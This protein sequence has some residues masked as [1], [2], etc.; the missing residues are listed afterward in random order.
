MLASLETTN[1]QSLGLHSGLGS[2][3]G[4]VFE[5]T[6]HGSEVAVKVLQINDERTMLDACHE[7]GQLHNLRHSKLV[8][9]YGA[10]VVVSLC[11]PSPLPKEHLSFVH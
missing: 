1:E 11:L 8:V 10:S 2:A 4:E 6:H 3:A 7:F 5:A 9:S